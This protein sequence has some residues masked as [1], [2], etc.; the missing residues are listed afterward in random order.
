MVA[1]VVDFLGA[2]VVEEA[3]EVM[4]RALGDRELKGVVVCISSLRPE[5]GESAK[6]REGP[7]GL[8]QGYAGAG[9]QREGRL[10][11]IGAGCGIA[12]TGGGY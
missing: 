10:C 5:V 1:S 8:L 3:G 4:P 7:E 11:A 12:Y 6:L 9:E 2:R